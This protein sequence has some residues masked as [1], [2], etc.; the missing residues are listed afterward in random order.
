M[1]VLGALEAGVLTVMASYNSWNDE[2]CHGHHY[3]LSQVLK[4]ELGFEEPAVADR[5]RVEVVRE[6]EFAGDAHQG[7]GWAG[8]LGS[9]GHGDCTDAEQREDEDE[10][11]GHSVGSHVR[12]RLSYLRVGRWLCGR[13]GVL[14]G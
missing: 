10:A 14:Q 3:L 1:S 7:V 4:G 8:R 13:M 11:R 9:C 12:F 2:K 5:G 6:N